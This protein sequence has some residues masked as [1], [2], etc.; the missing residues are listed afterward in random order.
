MRQVTFS[1]VEM[2]ILALFDLWGSYEISYESR[3]GN[4]RCNK[5]VRTLKG[6]A[7]QK[8]KNP[9]VWSTSLWL[10]WQRISC[11]AGDLC[12]IPGMGRCPGEGKGYP[13]QY[14]GLENSMDYPRACKESD[15]AELIS[16]PFSFGR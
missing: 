2:I 1:F 13:L 8:K 11:N 5:C 7:M 3:R 12:L 4:M 10:S 15:T 6:I 9:S 14:S 16:L